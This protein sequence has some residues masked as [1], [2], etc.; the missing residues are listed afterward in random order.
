MK[1]SKVEKRGSSSRDMVQVTPVQPLANEEYEV[2]AGY[3][4]RHLGLLVSTRGT[5]ARAPYYGCEPVATKTVM[6]VLGCLPGRMG[7]LVPAYV[8]ERGGMEGKGE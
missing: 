2:S 7:F 1:Q 3:P 4:A 6:P 5:A 8:G